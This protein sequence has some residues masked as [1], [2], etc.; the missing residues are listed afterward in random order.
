MYIPI[1]ELNLFNA[2][3]MK[4]VTS[5]WK[6]S[7]GEVHYDY[8]LEKIRDGGGENFLQGE[9]Q[10]GM[11]DDF[12]AD[13]YDLRGFR[14]WK[15]E[16]DFPR[17]DNIYALDLSYAKFWHSIF[18]DASWNASHCFDKFH[19]CK[20]INCQFH[21]TDFFGCSFE[22]CCFENCDF[23]QHNIFENS[24]FTNTKFINFFTSNKLFVNCRFSST[25][26]VSPPPRKLPNDGAWNIEFDEKLLKDFYINIRDAYKNGGAHD[27]EWN[28]YFL[29][30]HAGTRHNSQN[31]FDKL[32]KLFFQEYLMGYGEK[33][34]RCLLVSLFVVITFSILF[35]YSGFSV[36][37]YDLSDNVVSQI[38]DYDIDFPY[39]F[40]NIFNLSFH[41]SW[42]SDFA[43]SFYFNI[44]TFT[45]VGTS[46]MTPINKLGRIYLVGE[47]ISGVTLVGAWLATLFRK[48]IR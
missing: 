27:K 2:S 28:Y 40:R 22:N 16:I 5:R 48:L 23:I 4:Y 41:L 44:L 12:L 15:E 24:D 36:S 46:E 18:R 43:K 47:V 37:Y 8:I 25:V 14:F 13:E 35:M 34:Y 3:E 33:P 7:E 9:F 32:S 11:F 19:N 42:L 31:V 17:G 21:N 6:T 39:F 38:I 10:N 30:K 20:F 29:A 26:I 1:L 45:S